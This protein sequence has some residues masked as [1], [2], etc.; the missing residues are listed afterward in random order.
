[1]YSPPAGAGA[2]EA[3]A[4]PLGAAASSAGAPVLEDILPLLSGR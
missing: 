3:G 4:L 2:A 1:V